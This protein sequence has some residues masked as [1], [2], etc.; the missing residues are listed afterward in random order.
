V[1]HRPLIAVAGDGGL[2]RGDPRYQL[3]QDLG[4]A[5][6]D[7]RYRLVCGGHGGVMEAACRGAR[8][9]SAHTDGD[10]IG[11][12]PGLDPAEANP[13]VDVAL[14]TGLGHLRNMVVARSDALV[15]IGGQAGTLSEMALAW[16]HRRP[17]IG[18]RVPG[19][20]G[21]LADQRIDGRVRFPDRPD[22]KVYGVDHPDEV[23]ELLRWLVGVPR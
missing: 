10:V 2:G 11:I 20:S 5:L 1:D 23:V 18:F 13:W 21:R 7:A 12:L 3:A 9:S 19:W 8:E 14:P 4:R 22:D 16:I 15:A 6:V 17:V